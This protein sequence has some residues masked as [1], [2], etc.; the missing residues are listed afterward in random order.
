MPA[1]A[2]AADDEAEAENDTPAAGGAEEEEMDDE[3]WARKFM[4]SSLEEPAAKKAVEVVEAG[5]AARPDGADIEQDVGT[6]L[7]AAC[8]PCGE[9]RL[10]LLATDPK[11]KET[12]LETGRLFLRNLAFSCSDADLRALMTPFGPLASIHL[13]LSQTHKPLGTAY[14]SFASAPHAL[15][16]FEALD[17]KAFQ[18]RLLHILPGRARPGQKEGAGEALGFKGKQEQ[19]KKDAAGAMGNGREWEWSWLFM[20]VRLDPTQNRFS[21]WAH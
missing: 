1:V 8:C 2:E 4:T 5:S 18:G 6:L 7:L 10:T 20:N 16:A 17:G 14:V 15:A 11:P 12:I 13:P 3:A 21:Q 19:K 9:F